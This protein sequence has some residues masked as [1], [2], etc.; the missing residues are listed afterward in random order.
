MIDAKEFT[1]MGD[2]EIG[3]TDLSWGS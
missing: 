3:S 2:L 1:R